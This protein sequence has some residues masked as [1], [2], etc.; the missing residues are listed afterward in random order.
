MQQWAIF[1]PD[2]T[3]IPGTVRSSK[4]ESQRTMADPTW[5]TWAFYQ[6]KGY[7]VR[8]ITIE[9][10]GPSKKPDRSQAKK[11]GRRAA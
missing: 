4:I 3:P 7:V 5:V 8:K 1:K 9:Y 6:D 10:H 2:G 11:R